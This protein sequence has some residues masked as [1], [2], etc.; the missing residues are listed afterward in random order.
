M[1]PRRFQRGFIYLTT[2]ANGTGKTAFTLKEI[3][4]KQLKENRP[5]YWNGRFE[6][7]SDFGWTRIDAKE[8]ESAPDGAIFLFDECHN[9]FP[10]RPNSSKVPDYVKAFGEHRKRGFDFYLLTQH[11][12][13][14]DPFIRKIIA[15]PGWHRHLK[16]NFGSSLISHID[17]LAVCDR[18]EKPGAGKSG[19]VSIKPL[20]KEVYSWYKSAELHTA[21]VKIP[22]QVWVFGA[23]LLLIPLCG[24]LAVRLLNKNIVPK[25]DAVPG[26]IIAGGPGAPSSS[27]R[28][29]TTTEF[30][31]DYKPRIA[32]LMHTAPAYDKLTEPK[33][34]PVPA[35]CVQSAS[36]G[37][38]CYTQDATPYPVDLSMC[39]QLVA[40]GAFLAFLPEGERK[41]QPVKEHTVPTRVE[42]PAAPSGVTLIGGP[43]PE[44]AAGPEPVLQQPQRIASGKR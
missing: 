2:G 10:D 21:K 42:A 3:R 15:S 24:Y 17:Y 37:C 18:P 7:V 5:V 12:G 13:N 27:G 9:D 4:D 1:S 11:P 31:N 40:N 43:Q 16:R 44:P 22:K 41:V 39:Q 28:A 32:G 29:K 25:T 23:A 19:T 6:L 14:I 35:A 8:W 33:R 36:K 30:I 34:V 20:P 26:Q 38:K